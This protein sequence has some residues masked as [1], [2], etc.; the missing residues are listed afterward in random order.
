MN[1]YQRDGVNAVPTTGIPIVYENSTGRSAIQINGKEVLPMGGISN[2]TTIFCN[3]SGQYTIFKSDE[4]GFSNPP[5][6]WELKNVD[7][8]TL[9]DSNALGG[10]VPS[11]K[12]FVALVRQH[13]PATINAGYPGAGPLSMLGMLKEALSVTHPRFVLWFYHENDTLD[14]PFERTSPLLLR[15]LENTFTQNLLSRQKEVDEALGDYVEKQLVEAASKHLDVI[16]ALKTELPKLRPVAKLTTLRTFLAQ[17][18]GRSTQATDSNEIPKASLEL[19]S[20]ILSLA[21]EATSR[22]G[23]QL[24]FVFLPEWERYAHGSNASKDYETIFTAVKSLNIP[25]IDVQ[26]AFQSRKDPLSLFPFRRFGHYNEQGHNL[27]AE[28]VCSYLFP[29]WPPPVR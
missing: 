3:E 7:I 16:G 9:G 14:I 11:E 2:R 24:V 17:V 27:V 4:H 8:L 25:I 20:R 15:Y 13:Y 23:G 29:L 1:D 19:L 5:G 21:N 26:L 22:S 28:T 6:L 12:N 10:C 18:R